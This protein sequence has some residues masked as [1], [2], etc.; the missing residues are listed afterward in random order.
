MLITIDTID[1]GNEEPNRAST[2]PTA[3]SKHQIEPTATSVC[4][5]LAASSGSVPPSLRDFHT[6]GISANVRARYRANARP[7]ADTAL[8]PPTIATTLAA[9]LA[10]ILVS[11]AP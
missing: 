11:R 4:V 6:R 3:L 5:L 2:C 9:Q 10:H 8:P 7:A 1:D